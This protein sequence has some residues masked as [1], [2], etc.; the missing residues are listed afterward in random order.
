MAATILRYDSTGRKYQRH[1]ELGGSGANL[2]MT[3]AGLCQI[4][5]AS[6]V[7]SGNSSTA[8]T[9]TLNSGAGAAYDASVLP[10]TLST[11]TTALF[12]PSH[13][14]VVGEDDTFDVFAPLV[15]AVTAQIAVYSRTI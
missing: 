4:L 7:Y 9:F 1:T 13:M 5:W 2:T 10:V 14:M 6:V 3:V 12:L 15:S 11:A 8:V